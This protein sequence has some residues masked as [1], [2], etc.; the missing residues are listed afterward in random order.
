VDQKTGS[1]HSLDDTLTSY[2]D[3]GLT[4]WESLVV[5][6]SGDFSSREIAERAGLDPRTIQQIKQ[7]TITKSHDRNRALLTLIVAELAGEESERWGEVPP[8]EPLA[9]I[10]YYVDIRDRRRPVPGCVVCGTELAS[11]RR[12]YCG[13]ACRKI[14][15]RRRGSVTNSRFAPRP[16]S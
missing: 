13:E 11:R 10:A 4:A 12:R 6:A 14:A 1:G 2:G 8:S 15:Y 7:R 3:P 9:R 5:P 16:G